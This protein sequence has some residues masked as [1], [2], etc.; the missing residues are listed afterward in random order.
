MLQHFHYRLQS[1]STWLF[2]NSDFQKAKIIEESKFSR[3]S[4]SCKACRDVYQDFAISDHFLHYWQ[5]IRNILQDLRLIST[6]LQSG[7]TAS[8]LNNFFVLKNSFFFSNNVVG[9]FLLA[10]I[11]AQKQFFGRKFCFIV[12][13]LTSL[14][15]SC[16]GMKSCFEKYFSKLKALE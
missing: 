1:V 12:E 10:N 9:F 8:F 6:L 13:I 7:L 2:T 4:Y 3:I 11:S 16:L 5:E 15:K 14:H